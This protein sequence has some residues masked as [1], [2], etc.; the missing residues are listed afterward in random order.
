MQKPRQSIRQAVII[1]PIIMFTLFSFG[2]AQ[3]RVS[4][5]KDQPA[6]QAA[7]NLITIKITSFDNRLMTLTQPAGEMLTI[8]KDN[9]FLGITP[10]IVDDKVILE[11]SHISKIS[12]NNSIIGEHITSLGSM[13]MSSNLPQ[14]S[15]ISS[16]ASIQLIGISQTPKAPGAETN[17]AGCCLICE[18]GQQTCAKCVELY[19]GACGCN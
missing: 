1:S 6:L 17:R 19:C 2:W 15:F 13:D 10:R 12:N 16:I 14:A 18:D 4:K 5:L 8:G 3:G 7:E 11:F 9:E